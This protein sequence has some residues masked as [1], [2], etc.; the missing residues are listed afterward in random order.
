VFQEIRYFSAH[1]DIVFILLIRLRVMDC[2]LLVLV[3]VIISALGTPVVAGNTPANVFDLDYR[4]KGNGVD[5]PDGYWIYGTVQPT[6][7]IKK[8]MMNIVVEVTLLDSNGATLDVITSMVRQ[9]IVESG[10]K[11]SFLAKSTTKEE[12]ADIEYKMVSYEETDNIH[13]KYLE[14]STIWTVDNGVTGWLENI[15]DSFYVTEAEVIATFL[16]VEGNVVDIQNYEMNYMDK[17]DVGEKKQ[18]FCETEEEFDSYFLNVQCNLASRERYLRL[19]VER[20]N[21]VMNSWTPP[22]GETIQ[23]VLLDE[24][25]F[26]TDYVEAVITNPLGKSSTSRFVRSGLSDYRYEITPDIPGV[27]NVTW[28]TQPFAVDGWAWAEGAESDLGFFIWD[29]NAEKGTTNSTEPADLPSTDAAAT[30]S[31]T[32][33]GILTE[34]DETTSDSDSTTSST[35]E[36]IDSATSTAEELIESIPEEIKQRIPGYPVSSILVA[37]V[38]VYFLASRKN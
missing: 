13:F 2:R 36:I 27:W 17:F 8:S 32:P 18:W 31:T 29:P 20:P 25:H 10:Q 19:V 6:F 22:V 5:V 7:L 23:L 15:H 33:D 34:E 30:N 14:M 38:I 28:V 16:D 3:T 21:K 9:T 26:G 12:V 1:V 24:P 35:S 4:I 11:G 37:L